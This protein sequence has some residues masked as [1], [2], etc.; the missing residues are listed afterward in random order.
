M[1]TSRTDQ[2][3]G[4]AAAGPTARGNT[5]LG[6]ARSQGWR[7]SSAGAAC[8][9]HPA[10]TCHE[11]GDTTEGSCSPHHLPSHPPFPAPLPSSGT[12]FPP[13][14]SPDM[15]PEPTLVLSSENGCESQDPGA[16]CLQT[17]E[18]EH[19]CGLQQPLSFQDLSV[20][21]S[22]HAPMQLAAFCRTSPVP[23]E[24]LGSRV[25]GQDQAD[26]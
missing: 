8:G 3:L 7:Q 21:L 24:D 16:F 1:P 5:N 2:A 26:E 19:G 4:D 10:G 23:S 6:N 14:L 15:S 18:A 11:R 25:A 22:S 12:C 9:T 13:A 20:S 17:L